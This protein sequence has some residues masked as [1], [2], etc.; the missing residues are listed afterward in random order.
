MGIFRKL[1][2][3]LKK[4]RDNMSGKIEDV[5]G[6]YEEINDDLFDELEEALVM[7]DVGIQTA[8]DI[9]EELRKRVNKNEVRNPK[10]AKIIIQEIVSDMLQGGEDM[11]LVT[12]PSIILLIGVNG[13]G[14]TTTIGKMAAQFKAQGKKVILGAADTFRAAAIDQLEI[15]AQRAG[16]DMIKHAE[17]SDPAAVVFDTINAGIARDCDII[18]CDTAGRL[19]NKKNLMD[20]LAKIYRVIDRELPW[21]DREILLCLDATTGQNAV[22][23]AREFMNVAEI[24]GIVLT[25]LDGTARGGVVLSIKNEL[26]LPVRYIGVGE[27]I[28][29]LQPFN[30]T[31]FAKALF[32]NTA[33]T[34]KEEDDI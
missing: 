33:E 34:V 29:D 11:G 19:H 26:K 2:F 27:G 1:G 5:L 31:A 17:G 21:S 20:E 25:K 24:T 6:A 9:V 30:P 22:N 16:V 28:D 7:G 32:E 3:G 4:T 10:H 13:V 8:Q 18:I 23:Q 14:K 15:W 12:I